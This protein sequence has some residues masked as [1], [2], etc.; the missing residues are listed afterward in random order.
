ML[1]KWEKP[2]DARLEIFSVK[3]K[4][5]SLLIHSSHGATGNDICVTNTFTVKYSCKQKRKHTREAKQ[6]NLIINP[7]NALLNADKLR[8][9]NTTNMLSE[10]HI[11]RSIW[12]DEYFSVAL[13][14]FEHESWATKKESEKSQ[15]T[16]TYSS[17]FLSCRLARYY[18]SVHVVKEFK[19]AHPQAY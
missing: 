5:I 13:H 17:Q 1:G 3:S 10:F 9:E 18:F 19:W 14:L 11:S 16:L 4:Y 2:G 8:N 15:N 12:N 7:L 6:Q